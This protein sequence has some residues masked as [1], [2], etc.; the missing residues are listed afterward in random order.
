MKLFSIA[1]PLCIGML[2]DAAVVNPGS[3]PEKVPKSCSLTNIYVSVLL[4]TFSYKMLPFKKDPS[5]PARRAPPRPDKSPQPRTTP[6]S[7]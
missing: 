2:V 1:I 3:R 5:K 6:K 4:M 7:L